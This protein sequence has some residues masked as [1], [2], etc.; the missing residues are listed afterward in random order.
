[1]NVLCPVCHSPAGDGKHI[2][3]DT[4]FLCPNC[5]N[6]RMAGS[7]LAE[8]RNGKKLPT[9]AAFKGLVTEKKGKSTQWPV[10]TQ[11]DL[12]A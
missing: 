6:Y 9:P 4:V 8:V 5:G 12:P 1:M 7:L 11:Y 3:D 10:I 2:G